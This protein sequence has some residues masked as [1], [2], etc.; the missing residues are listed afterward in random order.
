MP[1]TD[2]RAWGLTDRSRSDAEVEGAASVLLD[3]VGLRRARAIDLVVVT[4]RAGIDLDPR[5]EPGCN[6]TF[7]PGWT[8]VRFCLRGSLSTIYR[9]LAHELGH[10][11]LAATGGRHHSEGDATRAGLALWVPRVALRAAIRDVGVDPMALAQRFPYVPPQLLWLRLA[12]VIDRAIIVHLGR[13][14]LVWEPEGIV[15]PPEGTWEHEREVIAQA[16]GAYR[17]LLGAEAW[18]V[19]DERGRR[20]TMLVMPPSD[21]A[22]AWGRIV[23]HTG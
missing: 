5:A 4:S 20:G 16:Q 2:P 6:A 3:A 21:D 17:D 13:E 14:R 9:M 7:D 23:A 19:E 10:Y 18:P 11:A 15:V 22:D 12:W 8:V 1:W